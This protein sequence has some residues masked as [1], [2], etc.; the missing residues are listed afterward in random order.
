MNINS[1]RVYFTDFFLINQK[2]RESKWLNEQT[3]GT[4]FDDIDVE[5]IEKQILE[6]TEAKK[7]KDFEKADSIR[8]NLDKRGILLKDTREGTIWD[9]KLLYSFN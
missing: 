9:L 7:S 2:Q 5:D 8:D 1:L 4:E 3:R 6:R